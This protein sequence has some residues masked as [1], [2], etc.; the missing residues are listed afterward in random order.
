MAQCVMAPLVWNRQD[1]PTTTKRDP[2]SGASD[3]TPLFPQKEAG[4]TSQKVILKY[5]DLY[6]ACYYRVITI[7]AAQLN[8]L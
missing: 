2:T 3:L 5:K 6:K 1:A 4:A 7:L 8:D